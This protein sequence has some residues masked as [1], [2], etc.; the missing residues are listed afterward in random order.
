MFIHWIKWFLGWVPKKSRTFKTES[1]QRRNVLS[2]REEWAFGAVAKS[3]LGML[4]HLSI[5]TSHPAS[6]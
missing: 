2:L 1:S 3:L 5:F 6:C 4:V